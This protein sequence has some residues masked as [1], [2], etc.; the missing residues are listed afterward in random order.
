MSTSDIDLFHNWK[1]LKQYISQLRTLVANMRVMYP[2]EPSNDSSIWS[3]KKGN[4]WWGAVW[5]RVLHGMAQKSYALNEVQYKHLTMIIQ[6]IEKY[7]E[8]I[9]NEQVDIDDLDTE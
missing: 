5:N 7:I 8:M 3:Q 6:Q 2:Q 4:V 9:E 1:N